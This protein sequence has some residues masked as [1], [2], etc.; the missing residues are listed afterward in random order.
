MKVTPSANVN[1]VCV[2]SHFKGEEFL[3]ECK[4]LGAHVVLITRERTRN[5]KWPR[6]S[7]DEVVFLQDDAGAEVMLHVVGQLARSRKPDVLVALEEFDV[8]TTALARE[9]LR[10][11]GMTSTEAR[12]FR[13]KLAMRVSAADAGLLVPEF[14]SLFNL[15]DVSEYIARVPPPWVLKPRSDVSASGIRLLHEPEQVWR[16]IEELDARAP[17]QDR[18]FYYLLERYVAGQVFH[19]DSLTEDGEVIFA[20]ANRYGSPPMDVAH[21][22]GVFTSQ[23]VEYDSE[24]HKE[25]MSTNSELLRALG[26]RRGAAHAEFIRGDAD[27]RFYFLEVAARVGGAFIAET[28]EAATGVNLWSAWARVEEAHA[29]GEKIGPVQARREYGG[30]ALSLARQERPDT[31]RF[32]DP[33]IVWRVEKPFHVGLII[34]SEKSERVRELLGHY[35]ERFDA[36]FS[37]YVAPPDRREVNL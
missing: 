10:M 17:L 19:V 32:D 7:L 6:E 5:E 18:S 9:H 25:L 36:E 12:R 4:R 1:V 14:T 22:G 37:A 33:E 8:I 34:R 35:S 29:R 15:Q 11:T 13:D 26:L 30:I 23:T 21:G 31:T 20:G 16:S 27:G 2:A 24:D 3:R 28:V